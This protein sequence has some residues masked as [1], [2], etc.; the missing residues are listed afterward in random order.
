LSDVVQSADTYGSAASE[1][2]R[3]ETPAHER[4]L[5]SRWSSAHGAGAYAYE[6]KEATVKRVEALIS[7]RTGLYSPVGGSHGRPV[8]IPHFETALDAVIGLTKIPTITHKRPTPILR[9]AI[10]RLL[11]ASVTPKEAATVVGTLAVSLNSLDQLKIG[12]VSSRRGSLAIIRAF[13]AAVCPEVLCE[14]GLTIRLATAQSNFGCYCPRF[15]QMLPE[16][17]PPEPNTRFVSTLLQHAGRLAAERHFPPIPE[18]CAAFLLDT[19]SRLAPDFTTRE[20]SNCYRG[21]GHLAPVMPQ[22]HPE[23]LHAALSAAARR[24][25][26]TEV[27]PI[28]A[29]LAHLKWSVSDADVA[30]LS[31]AAAT[32][33]SPRQPLSVKLVW[34]LSKAFF[35]LGRPVQGLLLTAMYSSLESSTLQAFQSWRVIEALAYL[36]DGVW[37]GRRDALLLSIEAKIRHSPPSLVQELLSS[38]II[39]FRHWPRAQALL[40]PDILQTV[41]LRGEMAFTADALAGAL[42]FVA[43]GREALV[44]PSRSRLVGL[45]YDQLDLMQPPAVAVTL[46]SL[47]KLHPPLPPN[48]VNALVLAAQ[49]TVPAMSPPL[50]LQALD[51]LRRIKVPLEQDERRRLADAAGVIVSNVPSADMPKA[52]AAIHGLAL[53][54]EFQSADDDGSLVER[55]AVGAVSLAVQQAALTLP[56]TKFMDLLFISASLVSWP[57][58]TFILRRTAIDT[59]AEGAAKL[60]PEFDALEVSMALWSLAVLKAPLSQPAVDAL[61]ESAAVQAPAMKAWAVQSTLW[62]I[63]KLSLVFDGDLRDRMLAAV[64]RTAQKMYPDGV[65]K[66]LWA[67]GRLN[68]PLEGDGYTALL[69]AAAKTAPDMQAGMLQAASYGLQEL[70]VP[71]SAAARIAVDGMLESRRAHVER[72]VAAAD[73][74]AWGAQVGSLSNWQAALEERDGADAADGGESIV[75]AAAEWD[76]P[77]QQRI[78]DLDAAAEAEEE[79]EEEGEAGGGGE[80]GEV[81]EEGWGG[82]AGEVRQVGGQGLSLVGRAWQGIEPVQDWAKEAD[83]AWAVSGVG[84][85][86]DR[87]WEEENLEGVVDLY[88]EHKGK[89]KWQRMDVYIPDNGRAEDTKSGSDGSEEESDDAGATGTPISAD[90][91][92]LWEGTADVA[93]GSEQKEKSTEV[94][95]GAEEEGGADSE[96]KGDALN[97]WDVGEVVADESQREK[98]GWFDIA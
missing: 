53:H 42:R 18:A 34:S 77:E 65:A 66:T 6:L 96:K 20:L 51:G 45:I 64:A 9:D 58:D 40:P 76:S 38:L 39:L 81:W 23:A 52:L 72:L 85:E 94:E 10:V 11:E 15:W 27:E 98:S 44:E 8:E 82:E 88:A 90:V 80:V 49:R 71:D 61:L 7:V 79:A 97:V 55:E 69:T 5:G 14:L 24:L 70:D 41:A 4:V 3:F 59:L 32:T 68:A 31:D 93:D 48:F 29:S 35:A 12:L 95:D 87:S 36:D 73:D 28:V 57:A 86:G 25:Q 75:A 2:T 83:T 63:A 50:A 17:A 91:V 92:A 47:G 60:A 37:G 13:E 22:E 67:L 1:V 16:H 89:A 84:G 54:K 19:A 62:A 30:E 21:C 56:K 33:I 74:N 46:W 43:A 78:S 26:Y